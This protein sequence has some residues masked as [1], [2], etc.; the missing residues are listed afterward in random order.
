MNDARVAVNMSPKR[1]AHWTPKGWTRKKERRFQDWL[2]AGA[3]G[4]VAGNA[5]ISDSPEAREMFDAMVK[6][7]EQMDERD[8]AIAELV[9][10][11]G[12]AA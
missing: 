7:L 12:G 2:E 9:R 11:S 6:Q 4:I 8:A 10:R 3:P 5:P 1:P